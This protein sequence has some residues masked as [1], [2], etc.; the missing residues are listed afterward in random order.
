M[1]KQPTFFDFAAQVGLTKH[2]GG[3]DATEA[4]IE[5]C[6]IDEHKYVLDVGC[7]VGVTPTY[8]AKRYGTRVVG[9]DL[10]AKM[11]ERSEERASRER[12]ADRVD[13]RVADAQ[14]LPFDDGLFD[15]VITESVAALTADQPRAINEF[16]RVTKPGGYVGL[17]ESVWLKVPP[18]PEVV[19]WA[20]QDIGSAVKPLTRDE[21][22][23]LL[24]GAGL[25]EIIVKTF[26]IKIQDETK[27]ILQRYGLVGM[28]RVMSR[29]L[30]LYIR[31]SA[32]RKFVQSTRDS[33]VIP[34]N[35]DEYFGYG[36][37]VGR[38]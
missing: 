4:L 1:E 31:S 29:M 19:A 33:G 9:V 6:H 11:I 35:L 3:I 30:A 37:F 32:Y 14:E 18:P 28:L 16:A 26:E 5:L 23:G 10:C 20:S 21:W 13:F 2:I 7:G 12:V 17:N 22:V 38:K 15:A 34:E 25:Q 27:G 24:Q 36:L 8:M